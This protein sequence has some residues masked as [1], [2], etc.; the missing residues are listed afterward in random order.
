MKD[1]EHALVNPLAEGGRVVS[2]LGRRLG[3]DGFPGSRQNVHVTIDPVTGADTPGV[4]TMIAD[5]AWDPETGL[6]L[7]VSENGGL[8]VSSTLLGEGYALA[9]W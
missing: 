8:G 3:A 5:W 7:V 9:A 2:V 6:F 1:A 4:Q